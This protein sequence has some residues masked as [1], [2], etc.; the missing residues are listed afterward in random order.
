MSDY[1]F[2][3][4]NHLS[5]EQTR[6]LEELQA[7]AAKA[8]VNLFLAG[9]AMRDMLGGFPIRDLDFTVEGPAIKI[10]KAIAEKTGAAVVSVDDTR[11]AVELRFSG[12]VTAEISMARQERYAKAGGRPVVT[13]AT[14]HEDLRGRDFAVNSIAL[15]LNRASRG[16]LLDPNNGLA[17]LERKELRAAGNYV[18]YDDPVR[19]LRLHRLR[20]RLNFTIEDRTRMQYENAREAQMEAHIG[21]AALGR[22]LRAIAVEAN[23]GEVLHTLAEERLLKLYSPAL[24]GA[25]LNQQGFAKLLKARQL[26]PAGIQ[27]YA[28]D[29]PLFLYLLTEKLNAKETAALVEKAALERAETGAWLKLEAKSKKLEKELKSAKLTKPSALYQALVKAEGNQI[30]FLLIYSQQRI[31]HDRLRN[32]LQKYLPAAQEIADNEL[33]GLTD[34]KPGTPK[35]AK[36]KEE[37]IYARLDGRSKKPAPPVE[38]APPPGP[39]M[40]RARG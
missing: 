17:D 11:K 34:A 19:L 32:Y 15:S 39:G 30:L 25:K 3:L 21:A 20:V 10:G 6:V 38:E 4:E 23:A 33:E 27:F 12:G 24:E 36:A 5:T 13:P 31:I 9:G 18:F 14:I 1:L 35:F 29:L 22:E 2:M 16:L 8:N 28:D 7:Y 26:V 37:L 40:A